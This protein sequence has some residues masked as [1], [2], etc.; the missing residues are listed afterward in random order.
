[1]SH[2]RYKAKQLA[3]GQGAAA[4]QKLLARCEELEARIQTLETIACEG[5][6][7]AVAQLKAKA[8]RALPSKKDE[9]GF[10]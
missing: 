4:D 5:D 9:E 1:V 3:A 6:L 7:G 10:K 8:Q 2:Y